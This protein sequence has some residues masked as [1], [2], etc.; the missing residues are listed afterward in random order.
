[1]AKN[2][3]IEQRPDVADQGV[4]VGEF[5]PP[6]GDEKALAVS[7]E[8]IPMIRPEDRSADPVIAQVNPEDVEAWK[9][10]GWVI[11]E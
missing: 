1:M 2:A 3:Q 11:R 4:P 8:M 6:A 9:K 10:H 7:A 5:M